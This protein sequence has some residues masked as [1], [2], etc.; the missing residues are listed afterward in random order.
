MGETVLR[1][2]RQQHQ[3]EQQQQTQTEHLKTPTEHENETQLPDAIQDSHHSHMQLQA[4]A[5]LLHALDER[6][7]K[8]SA[9][10][11]LL[12][13]KASLSSPEWTR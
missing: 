8:T 11:P 3:E 12:V 9:R 6:P 10:L 1:E 7:K 13:A 5:R 2:M 4:L